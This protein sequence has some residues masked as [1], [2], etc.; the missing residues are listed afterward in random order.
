M[1]IN[2]NIDIVPGTT[3]GAFVPMTITFIADKYLSV[4][5]LK[6]DL[7]NTSPSAYEL[8]DITFKEVENDL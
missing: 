2:T 5:T 3:P 4:E 1:N 7:I 6:G 8:K